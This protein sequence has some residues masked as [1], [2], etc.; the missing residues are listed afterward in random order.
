[1]GIRIPLVVGAGVAMVVGLA[2]MNLWRGPASE[3][4]A[5]T[6]PSAAASDV[7]VPVMRRDQ[8]D[9][10]P[11]TAS[12]PLEW[13]DAVTIQNAG[14]SAPATAISNLDPGIS[15]LQ[16]LDDPAYRRARL[17][18]FRAQV[19]KNHPGLVEELRLTPEEADALF[20]LLAETRLALAVAAAVAADQPDDAAAARRSART[21]RD[22]LGEQSNAL[23]TLLGETRYPLWQDYQDARPAWLKA[24][25]YAGSLAQAGLPLDFTQTRAIA[26]A[27][28][29]EQQRL[30]QDVLALAR[31]VV[32]AYPETQAQAQAALRRRQAESDQQVLFAASPYLSVEQQQAL[33]SQLRQ[34]GTAAPASGQ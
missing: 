32:L 3:G 27:V 14:I 23:R 18:E 33:R 8:A 22:L 15:E 16:R 1:M 11:A 9:A 17:E 28:I 34:Q 10:A 31:N 5:D 30:S 6:T 7:Q 25:A 20:D 2:T 4:A 21:R 13:A 29:E 19:E 12:A 26:M 24:S